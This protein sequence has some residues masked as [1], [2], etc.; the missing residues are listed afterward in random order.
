MVINAGVEDGGPPFGVSNFM[1]HAWFDKV[2]TELTY[3]DEFPPLFVSLNG[4]LL[5]CYVLLI[6]YKASKLISAS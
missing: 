4:K 6:S 1:I 2:I 5:I 3:N